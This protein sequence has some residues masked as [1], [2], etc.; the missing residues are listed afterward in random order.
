MSSQVGWRGSVMAGG[1]VH[2]TEPLVQMQYGDPDLAPLRPMF[3]LEYRP[4]GASG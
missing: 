2:G 3:D 4:P 1:Y